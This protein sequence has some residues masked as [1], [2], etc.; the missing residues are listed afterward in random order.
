M[1]TLKISIG[2]F[3][4]RIFQSSMKYRVI[5]WG[6]MAVST[7]AGIPYM[8]LMMVRCNLGITGKHCLGNDSV[9]N[10]AD[11]FRDATLV[12]NLA[13]DVAY[14]A[15]AIIAVS[16]MNM[17]LADKISAGLMISLGSIGGIASLVRLCVNVK[18]DFHGGSTFAIWALMEVGLGITAASLATLKPLKSQC[19]GCLR[20]RSSN[21]TS[22][23]RGLLRSTKDSKD[24]RVQ[25]MRKEEHTVTTT[26]YSIFSDVAELEE[27]LTTAYNRTERFQGSSKSNQQHS[28]GFV[29]PWDLH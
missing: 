26:M 9:I 3:F 11:G 14:A 2:L 10:V 21:T 18:A 25:D 29:P 23:C 7:I 1:L 16:V 12:A 19:V 4:A 22:S 5:C 6:I 24:S 13:T 28:Q 27:D 20:R 15:T 8:V 17:R